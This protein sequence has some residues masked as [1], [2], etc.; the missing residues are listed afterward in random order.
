MSFEELTEEQKDLILRAKR[1][2]NVLVDACIGSGKT[3]AIQVLCNEIHE[4]TILYLTYHTLLKLD[5]QRKI[6]QPNAIVTNY[7]GFAHM[8]L[9]KAED[10]TMLCGKQDLIQNFIKFKPV[11]GPYG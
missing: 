1:G 3:T 2:E 7:H 4:K 11:F 10:Q 8:C 6:V 9:N 5:A